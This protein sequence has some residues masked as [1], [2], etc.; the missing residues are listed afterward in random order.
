MKRHV[1]AGI[2]GD[3]ATQFLH[4]AHRVCFFHSMLW[5]AS[6][7]SVLRDLLCTIQIS[8]GMEALVGQGVNSFKFF[9][10]YKV[11]VEH[12]Q[13]CTVINTGTKFSMFALILSFS[14]LFFYTSSYV[15]P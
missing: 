9:M 2:Q 6:G 5:T 14:R 1:L 3:E 7:S 11:N 8:A 12:I 10:A 4:V 15:H 13:R